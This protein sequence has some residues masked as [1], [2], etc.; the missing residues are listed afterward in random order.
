MTRHLLSMGDLS[1][2]DIGAILD[3]TLACA[4]TPGRFA[5]RVAGRAVALVFEKSST[6]T[7]LACEVAVT[8]LGGHPVTIAGTDLQI[9]RGE[10][11]EDSARVFSRFV[12]AVC[13]RTT[14]HDRLE[15]FARAATVPVI[16]TLSDLEHPCQVL[17]DL[18]TLRQRLGR[19]LP[20]LAYVGDGGNNMSHSWLLAAGALGLDLR[21]ATPRGYAPDAAVI[22]RARALARRSG[23]RLLVTDDPRTA[24]RGAGVFYT[25][26]WV[27]M[28]QEAGRAARLRAFRRFQVNE[29]LMRL[30]RPGAVA[31]HCLPAHRGEEISAGVMDSRRAIVWDQAAMR[32]PSHM[33]AL[34]WCMGTRK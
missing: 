24:A 28:G 4:R 6:R 9:G 14:G 30:G 34:L 18:A 29:A 1:A 16:N 32:L 23:A 19:R 7:R 25:D 13:W 33:A 12:D 10:T 26:V 5:R 17:A 11:I 2:R 21:I 27:S 20:P 22:A 8:R 3:L 15:R 31:M